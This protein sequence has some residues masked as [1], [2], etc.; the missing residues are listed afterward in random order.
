MGDDLQRR[1]MSNDLCFYAP[2]TL[3]DETFSVEFL[4]VTKKEGGT[5]VQASIVDSLE[6]V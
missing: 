5:G 3:D 6:K 2:F 4:M 1:S